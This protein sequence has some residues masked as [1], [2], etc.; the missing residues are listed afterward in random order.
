MFKGKDLNNLETILSMD[1]GKGLLKLAVYFREEKNSEI[2][3][4]NC[5]E[6]QEK[7]EDTN[8]NDNK[9]VNVKVKSVKDEKVKEASVKQSFLFSV[10]TPSFFKLNI[11][12]T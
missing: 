11:I 2:V 3:E 5:R 10:S 9:N 7:C 1:E 4:D 8:C 6:L 12:Y